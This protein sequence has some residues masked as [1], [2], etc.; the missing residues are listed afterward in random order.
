[1]KGIIF[2]VAAATTLCLAPPAHAF[3]GDPLDF[4]YVTYL[5]NHGITVPD[6]MVEAAGMFARRIC[7]LAADGAT[8]S[9]IDILVHSHYD[10]VG[11][12]QTLVI[13]QGAATFYCPP[14]KYQAGPNV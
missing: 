2:T 12:I 11:P 4:V 1:M 6:N 8:L 7:T 5:S 13:E 10:N 3:P 9:E 14:S